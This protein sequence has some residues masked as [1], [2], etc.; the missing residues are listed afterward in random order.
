MSFHGLIALL[1]TWA[2]GVKSLG[3]VK[4][5]RSG[6]SAFDLLTDLL[7][8]LDSEGKIRVNADASLLN[9]D[10]I[11]RRLTLLQL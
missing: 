10:S 7:T 3:G 6:Q 4:D 5:S 11:G 9:G 2:H 1:A 8:D